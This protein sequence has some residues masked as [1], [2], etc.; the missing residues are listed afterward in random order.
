MVMKNTICILML[1]NI[2]T[3]IHRGLMY[4]SIFGIII[5]T[6]STSNLHKKDTGS[7]DTMFRYVTHVITDAI[8]THR[9]ARLP[10]EQFGQILHK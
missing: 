3:G 2:V 7:Q 10:T 8:G 9:N 5:G 6:Q 1:L 4:F